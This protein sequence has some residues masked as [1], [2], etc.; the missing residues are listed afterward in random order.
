MSKLEFN[1]NDFN[2]NYWES[3]TVEAAIKI[4]NDKFDAWLESQQVVYGNTRTSW[5]TVQH[6]V[7]D[8]YSARIVCIESLAPKTCEHEPMYTAG[9]TLTLQ[10]DGAFVVNME[11]FTCRHCNKQIKAKRE[12]D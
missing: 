10:P 11:T 9:K 4:A 7:V 5:Y 12:A 3:I 8:I 6:Q 1:L 2:V